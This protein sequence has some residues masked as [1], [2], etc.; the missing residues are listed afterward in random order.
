MEEVV[1]EAGGGGDFGDL[2]GVAGADDG[3]VDARLGEGPADGE[4][5]DG[6]VV[7]GGE[8][9]QSIERL[10]GLFERVALEDVVVGSAV[11]RGESVAASDSAGQKAFHE[12][13]KD[14]DFDLT[15]DAVGDELLLCSGLQQVETALGH[16]DR[17]VVGERVNLFDG[18]VADADAIGHA[19]VVNFGHRGGRGG[20]RDGRVDVVQQQR[21]EAVE[22]ASTQR[23]FG[24]AAECVGVTANDPA[25]V[26][27][28]LSD[29]G[30]DCVTVAIGR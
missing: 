28:P 10:L 3:G 27:V 16:R 7:G 22:V 11:A 30:G 4:L 29:F 17:A 15:C 26:F 23:G 25:A 9:V 21:V 20:D 12:R 1:W 2:F 8:P 6:L 24:V 18:G 19:V 14:V 5:G 13:P